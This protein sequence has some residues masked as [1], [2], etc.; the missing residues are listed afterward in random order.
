VTATPSETTAVGV[1]A[2]LWQRDGTLTCW[3]DRGDD[4]P[5]LEL[6]LPAAWTATHRPTALFYENSERLAGAGDRVRVS[7]SLSAEDGR[8][9]LRLTSPPVVVT[10]AGARTVR[11]VGWRW[12]GVVMCASWIVFGVL[13]LLFGSLHVLGGLWLTL[14][15]V[16]LPSALLYLHEER[17]DTRLAGLLG[18]Y[19]AL[20][21]PWGPLGSWFVRR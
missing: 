12:N 3:I 18:W 6:Q 19:A 5:H 9:V 16:G 8:E 4:L 7:G 20:S 15:A 13:E 17:R 2:G 11:R 10:S 1:L 14:G 21:R